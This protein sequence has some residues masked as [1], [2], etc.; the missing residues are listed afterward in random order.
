MTIHSSIT[1]TG[2]PDLMQ[3]PRLKLSK[4]AMLYLFIIILIIPLPAVATDTQ[5][6]L[7]CDGR[8]PLTVVLAGYGL[9][10]ESWPPVF[11]E[12]GIRIKDEHF[13]SGR[14]VAV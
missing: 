12:T 2:L 1:P 3:A 13:T 8:S 14:P 5:I 6:T 11:F 9:V 10:T 7:Q 4:Q